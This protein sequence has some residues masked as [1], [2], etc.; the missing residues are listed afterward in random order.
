MHCAARTFSADVDTCSAHA[1]ESGHPVLGQSTGSPL[2]RGRADYAPMTDVA[3]A[4]TLRTPGTGRR[5]LIAHLFTLLVL[6]AW[7][8]ASLVAPS[9]LLPSPA[10]VAWRLSQFATSARDLGHLG[11][12]LRHV[13]LA[14][15]ISFVI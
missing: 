10:Q 1:R 12:S 15:A 2:S 11:A 5:A 9:Y 14:I 8:A 6:A 7:Q 4:A 3:L 13:A